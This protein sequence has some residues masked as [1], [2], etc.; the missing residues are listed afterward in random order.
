[1][2]LQFRI[3]FWTMYESRAPKKM[4]VIENFGRTFFGK[5]EQGIKN[6]FTHNG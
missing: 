6:A 3:V 1:M 2:K 4:A 5:S